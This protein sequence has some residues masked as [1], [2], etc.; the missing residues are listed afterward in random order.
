LFTECSVLIKRALS[1][2]LCRLFI[3]LK[4]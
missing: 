4:Q 2:R 1:H 3:L